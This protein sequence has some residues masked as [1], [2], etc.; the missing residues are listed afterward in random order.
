MCVEESQ[1]PRTHAKSKHIF[2]LLWSPMFFSNTITLYLWRLLTP[3]PNPN[4]YPDSSMLRPA[5]WPRGCAWPRA[6][7]CRWPWR[8][9]VDG[10][11]SAA[12]HFDSF[13]LWYV[14]KCYLLTHLIRESIEGRICVWPS[15][16]PLTHHRCPISG[17]WIKKETSSGRLLLGCPRHWE[18][19]RSLSIQKESPDSSRASFGLSG[20]VRGT[21]RGDATEPAVCAEPD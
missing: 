19:T 17:R 14:Y 12:R 6:T 5:G 21:N 15:C 11:F 16:V 18:L 10:V 13:G 2:L 3:H 7:L 20:R 8:S 1:V 4:L 9:Y